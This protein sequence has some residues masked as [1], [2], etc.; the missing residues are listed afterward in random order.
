MHISAFGSS[1]ARRTGAQLHAHARVH[2]T[3]TT[4]QPRRVH[5]SGVRPSV[6]APAAAPVAACRSRLR[7]NRPSVHPSA[8]HSP[9]SPRTKTDG[10]SRSHPAAARSTSSAPLARTARQE[11]SAA[12]RNEADRHAL[13]GR[14]RQRS[15]RSRSRAARVPRRRRH[16]RTESARQA[17]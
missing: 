12:A 9:T 13:R 10:V 17:R 8:A 7:D 6:S 3:H 1:P 5:T 14:R 16:L 11:P 4:M 2:P 15:T